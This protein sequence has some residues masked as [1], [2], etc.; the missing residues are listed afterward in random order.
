VPLSARHKAHQTLDDGVVEYG[1][2]YADHILKNDVLPMVVEKRL[3]QVILLK[4]K[5]R[6]GEVTIDTKN[7]A[8]WTAYAHGQ[9]IDNGPDPIKSGPQDD[10]NEFEKICNAY[11]NNTANIEKEAITHCQIVRDEYV[12]QVASKAAWAANAIEIAGKMYQLELNPCPSIDH[13]IPP[14][15]FP[16]ETNQRIHLSQLWSEAYLC[17]TEDTAEEGYVIKFAVPGDPR[18]L[19]NWFNFGVKAY[20]DEWKIALTESSGRWLARSGPGDSGTQQIVGK[21]P[22]DAN[23]QDAGVQ[24]WN[25]FTVTLLGGDLIDLQSNRSKYCTYKQQ[26]PNKFVLFAPLDQDKIGYCSVFHYKI[27]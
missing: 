5:L 16:F 2:I 25:K 11:S 22:F 7:I 9:F 1:K 14:I 20:P 17:R 19:E 27:L 12:N 13:P 4:A 18:N 15:P 24:G 21:E 3:E 10:P 23:K 8:W 26:G 6:P